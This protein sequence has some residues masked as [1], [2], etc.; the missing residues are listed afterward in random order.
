MINSY[1]TFLA[2][3]NVYI[4]MWYRWVG[5]RQ[6]SCSL[7]SQKAVTAN[8]YSEQ[9]L[10]FGFA[11]QHSL[12][13]RPKHIFALLSEPLKSRTDGSSGEATKQGGILQ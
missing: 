13:A 1:F 10:P 9:L 8:F 4:M 7:Q 6:Y 3:P 5:C 2:V 11:C 12:P